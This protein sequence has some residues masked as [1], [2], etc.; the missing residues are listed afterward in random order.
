VHTKHILHRDLKTQN[1]FIT[2]ARDGTM[3]LVKLGDFGIAKVLEGSYAAASTVIGTPYYMSPE[4][5][6]GQQYGYMSD[7]WALGCI[8]YEI[9]A[10]QQAWNGSNL[11]GLVY[12]IVQ[13]R[14][15]PLPDTYSAELRDLVSSMLS[16]DPAHRPSLPQILALPC[17]RGRIQSGL[18]FKDPPRPDVAAPQPAQV[19]SMALPQ[20]QPL[21]TAT[22][23]GMPVRGVA[24]PSSSRGSSRGGSRPTSAEV[25]QGA[26]PPTPNSAR[27]QTPLSAMPPTPGAAASK[28]SL[29]PVR[30]ST[31]GSKAA[32][33]GSGP[34]VSSAFPPPGSGASPRTP[35]APQAASAAC[36]TPRHM[37]FQPPELRE[38]DLG[39]ATQASPCA[40]CGSPAGGSMGACAG[41]GNGSCGVAT[42]PTLSAEPTIPAAALTPSQKLQRRKQEE[43]DRRSVELRAAIA[44]EAGGGQNKELARKL[45]AQAFSSNLGTGCVPDN[46]HG[47]CG[48][49]AG[50]WAGVGGGGGT[51][52]VS[53]S[54]AP[55]TATD[56]AAP[57]AALSHQPLAPTKHACGYDGV[58]AIAATQRF[59]AGPSQPP[60][61]G[62]Q[63]PPSQQAYAHQ[64]SGAALTAVGTRPAASPGRGLG[65]TVGTLMTEHYEDDF[66]DEYEVEEEL[67]NDQDDGTLKLAR[68]QAEARSRAHADA[69]QQ[70]LLVLAREHFNAPAPTYVAPQP[71]TLS[72]TGGSS[73]G[74]SAQSR[75]VAH[76]SQLSCAEM[77]ISDR[78]GSGGGAFL[79][80][81]AA[82]Q[83]PKPSLGAVRHA[84]LQERCRQALGDLF[85]S[86]Y[87]YLSRARSE[88]A[89]ER[90][91]RKTL[92]SLVGPHRLND[93]MCVDELVFTEQYG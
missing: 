20:Q 66:E 36:Y 81:S 85:P 32:R 92:Q 30:A 33:P 49:S 7:V 2:K 29:L 11:L 74:G 89:E 58:P 14:Q 17:I 16:K 52:S 78:G 27:R 31:P 70:R 62:Q 80:A 28:P 21:P 46:A 90:E 83:P 51:A 50:R 55:C 93:C 56:F 22:G 19:R 84:A 38:R 12:K 9:C 26:I 45:A 87:S 79:P 73:I 72:A 6:Q 3:G 18:G 59:A 37:L 91:V 69:H 42:P 13:E 48:A 5:C 67:S 88:M 53:S 57:N 23:P 75:G 68:Q 40:C 39:G 63:Q 82:Q 60:P 34:R 8:L 47:A 10:L 1:I 15:P 24:G 76:P 35:G 54:C 25:P 71:S 43:A 61:Y 41:G 77:S 44:A 86:V 65:S 4:V 64:P